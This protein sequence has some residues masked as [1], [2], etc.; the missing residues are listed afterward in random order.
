MT[1]KRRADALNEAT[2]QLKRVKSV[3]DETAEELVCAITMALPVDPVVAQD[4]HVYERSAVEDWIAQGNG[5][6]PKTNEPM[7]PA[8]L[9]APQV[10]AMIRGMVKSGALTGDKAEAWEE[11]LKEEEMG[12]GWRVKAEGGDAVA[13]YN[14]GACYLGGQWGVRKD[15]AE[16]FRWTQ[17]SADAGCDEG[18]AQLGGCYM[19]GWGVAKNT[20]FGMSYL[21]D[22]AR[23]GSQIG[24]YWLGHG[25][26]HGLHGL[27]KD[28][29]LATKWFRKMQACTSKTA[30]SQ[31][32]EEQAA[33]WL[34]E[35][36]T[37]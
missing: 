17:R 11:K 8:L 18:L 1:P 15:L 26:A 22:G 29:K 37:D 28:A 23:G 4:G 12:R 16:G 5:K 14:V 35:H 31:K 13:I 7:G 34:R 33:A 10:K 21:A 36:A 19:F 27:P 24:C 6:S 9:P 32:I 2:A 30:T 25:F 20:T 3:V